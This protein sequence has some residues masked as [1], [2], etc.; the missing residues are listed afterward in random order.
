MAAV[1]LA[2]EILDAEGFEGQ[3]REHDDAVVAL[4][5]VERDILIAEPPEPLQRK[6]V[7]GTFGFLQTKHVRALAR[8]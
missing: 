2:A 1:G 7:V 8:Y 4:L 6:F 5:S 3:P